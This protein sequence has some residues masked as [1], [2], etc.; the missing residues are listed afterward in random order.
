LSPFFIFF[1]DL[2]KEIDPVAVIAVC[3]SFLNLLA[4]VTIAVAL[5]RRGRKASTSRAEKDY[6]IQLCRDLHEPLHAVNEEYSKIWRKRT[7][8]TSDNNEDLRHLIFR[9]TGLINTLATALESCTLDEA[10]KWKISL[11]TAYRK[12]RNATTVN[13]IGHTRTF[14]L[15]LE[16][17]RAQSRASREFLQVLSRLVFDINGS[18]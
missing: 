6:L 18:P 8:L 1:V 17:V 9:L 12:F 11:T 16:D 3:I 15:G 13:T 2:K 14:D 7:A 10:D 5:N 4:T